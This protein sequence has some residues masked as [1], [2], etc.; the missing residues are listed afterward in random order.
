MRFEFLSSVIPKTISIVFHDEFIDEVH[1]DKFPILGEIT[2]LDFNFF[3]DDVFY[4]A[5]L[6]TR[7]VPVLILLLL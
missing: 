3:F 1:S 4:Q 6:L 2:L 7:V 5:V